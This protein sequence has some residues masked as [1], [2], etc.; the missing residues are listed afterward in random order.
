MRRMLTLKTALMAVM[1]VGL[2]MPGWAESPK[3]KMTTSVPPGI[4]I[5][6]N[7]KTRLGMLKFFDGFPDKKTV[8]TLYDNLDFQRAVQAY[9]L[10]LAPVSQ[11][12][13][14]KG[15]L[16]VGPANTTVPIFETMMNARS[17]FLTPNNNTPYTWFWLDLRSGPL[18]L[19]VPPKV[20]GAIDDMWYRFVTDLGMVGPDKGEGGK[21]LLLPPGYKGDVP[22]GYFV[23]Q[24]STFSVWVP[25]RTFLV[26]GDPKPGVDMVKKFT[27]IYPLSQAANPPA[28]NFVNVSGRDFCTVA[29]A[30]YAFWEYLNQVVQ[31]EPTESVDPVTLGFYASIGIQKG[32]PFAPDARMKK[33][34]TEAAAVGD[35]TARAINYHMRLKEAFFYPNSAWRSGFLGGYK[36]EDNGALILDSHSAF[37]F[38]ATGVTPAMDSKVVG[39]GSQYMAAFVDAKGKPLDGGKNYKLHLP[40]HIPVANFWSVILY[41][42]QTRSMLQTDQQWPAVSSQTK[43]LL[44]NPDS[45][46]DVY[47][48]PKPPPGKEPNWVQT[49]PG[50]GWNTLLR[51]Y[52]PL[53][54]WFD[55][56][57]RPGEIELVK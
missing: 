46:V 56:T 43:G 47:F 28:L 13:N 5:P 17:I 21:Y 4:T 9:L 57:W 49:I 30:D 41:D 32:K 7:V 6:D 11:V 19:E 55:K 25:W 24:P 15:I 1:I 3:M 33:I 37:F 53:Q 22:E 10:G 12:A 48:G 51:L 38:Y 40:P 18:V 27:K 50:K 35:A 42:N 16:E 44:A 34:L 14:R 23:V 39:Q 8:D 26:N 31:E 2:A 20:L 45:S 54:P 52:G 36:F 29:P